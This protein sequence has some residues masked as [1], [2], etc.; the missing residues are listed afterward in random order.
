[1]EQDFDF[2]SRHLPLSFQRSGSR[3]AELLAA[4]TIV[5]AGSA[6]LITP[7]VMIFDRYYTIAL[8][9]CIFN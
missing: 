8:N 5:A 7:A 6:T 2:S 3:M 4:D 1:M 9:I